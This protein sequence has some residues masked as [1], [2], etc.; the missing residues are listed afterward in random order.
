MKLNDIIALGN[1]II[2]VLTDGTSTNLTVEVENFSG[3]KKYAK[4]TNFW[5]SDEASEYTLNIGDYDG[6][7]GNI[8]WCIGYFVTLY[9]F[10]S[11]TVKYFLFVGIQFSLFSWLALPTNL[12]SHEYWILRGWIKKFWN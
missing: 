6:T 9:L 8:H 5:I 4:Y 7:A 12:W 2:H 11:N 3:T 1:E 10:F